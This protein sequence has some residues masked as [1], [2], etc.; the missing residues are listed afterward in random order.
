MSMI[1]LASDMAIMPETV[2]EQMAFM[3]RL[4]DYESVSLVSQ[5][6]QRECDVSL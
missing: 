2:G 5:Q 6:D 3:V 1:L 4:Y